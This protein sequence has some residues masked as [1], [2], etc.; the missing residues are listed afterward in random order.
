MIFRKHI[1]QVASIIILVSIAFSIFS[2][3]ERVKALGTTELA[4]D[5][6]VSTGFCAIDAALENA[7]NTLISKGVEAIKEAAKKAATAVGDAIGTAIG[8]PGLGS[9]VGG[10]FGGSNGVIIE[11]DIPG[12]TKDFKDCIANELKRRLIARV[13]DDFFEWLANDGDPRFITDFREYLFEAQQDAELDFLAELSTAGVCPQNRHIVFTLLGGQDAGW[14]NSDNSGQNIVRC[15]VADVL[16]LENGGLEDYYADFRN[17]GWNAW[18]ELNKF[19]NT[20]LG[21]YAIAKNTRDQLKQI[22][23]DAKDSESIASQGFK[24]ETETVCVEE[25]EV[26]VGQGLV[27]TQC[28]KYAD[29]IITPGKTIADQTTQVVGA[30]FENLLNSD[31]WDEIVKGIIRTLARDLLEEGIGNIL[32]Q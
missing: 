7:V 21:Q 24:S 13:Q 11:K 15:S 1:R 10:L 20:P 2:P 14:E 32:D 18:I 25:V 12:E 31:E 19:H 17:G 3:I 29:K 23:Q 9:L 28:L 26:N 8:V 5:I 27:E 16:D 6:L 30:E 22:T 4:E